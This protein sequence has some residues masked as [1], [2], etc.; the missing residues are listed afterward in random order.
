MLFFSDSKIKIDTTFLQTHFQNFELDYSNT[1]FKCFLEITQEEN[2]LKIM[3]ITSQ[4]I[5]FKVYL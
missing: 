2:I 1:L 5:Y 4:N 3:S